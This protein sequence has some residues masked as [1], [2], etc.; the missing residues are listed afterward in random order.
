[1]T[2]G[3]GRHDPDFFVSY[4]QAD[5]AWAEWIAWALEDK[6]YHVL[7]QAWDF[8]PGTS[9]V[10]GM[11]DGTARAARTIAVL[12]P[13]YLTSVYGGAEWQAAWAA[14][15]DGAARKLIVFRVRDCAR[16]GLLA[17]VVGVDLF[18]LDE[19][20]ARSRL[21][22]S[23]AEAE[24]GRAKPTEPPRFP[25]NARAVPDEPRFPGAPAT[26]RWP[27]DSPPSKR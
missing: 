17:M 25:G 7:I 13:D 27:T 11:Q 14:D 6:G 3:D 5:R 20:T 23:I 2:G 19:P 15:P 16:P 24:A 22:R 4:T 1:M 21:L 9:W 26:P 10:Q 8:V 18:G 12:S